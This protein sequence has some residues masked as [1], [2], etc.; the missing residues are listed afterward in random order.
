MGAGPYALP[1]V[2]EINIA[3]FAHNIRLLQSRLPSSCQLMAVLKANAYGHGAIPLAA[4]ASQQ[5]VAALAVA[6]CEEGVDLR[7]AGMTAPIL[8]LGSVWP[9]EVETLVRCHLQSVVCS[10]EDATRLHNEARRHGQVHPVHLKV[11]TGMHRMGLSPEQV[12]VLL[13]RLTTWSNL[14]LEGVMT[15]L[16]TADSADS[17]TVQ[18]QLARF[19][20]VVQECARH[21]CVPR[22]LH[23]ANSAA[24]YRYP[25]SHWTLAR[26]GIALYGSHPFVAPAAAA[27][28]PVLSWK[29]RLA[30]VQEV[31]AGCG[32]SYGY[33][34][35]TPRRSVI[36]T[37][38]VGYADGLSRSLSDVGKVLVHGQRVALVGR[39]CMDM[40]MVDLT[41]V[42]QVQVGDEVV[43]IGAQ[44]NECITVDEMAAH[45]GQIPYEVLCAISQRVPRRYVERSLSP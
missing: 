41:D 34:F 22:Y 14:R 1:T 9:E 23:A 29:T 18:V 4:I 42:P 30:R 20:Q 32:I 19:T 11:D 17:H 45:S 39:I 10:L 36:G 16:A 2:A 7:Q 8:V 40:C 21:G 27:L 13:E 44:G 28:R 6:R 3:A 25:E 35:V 43:L 33:T 5:G 31:P 15:H 26:A 24:I 12:P 38:P 37:L